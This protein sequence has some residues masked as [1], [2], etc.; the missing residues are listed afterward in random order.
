MAPSV[1]V[2]YDGTSNDDD[3]LA[4]ARQLAAAGAGLAL[5]YVRHSREYDPRREEIAE[6]DAA[7]RLEQGAAWLEDPDITRHVVVDPSTST[8]LARLAAET[9]AQ[10]VLF[11]SDYRTTPGRAEPGGTAQGLL[12]GGSVA[13]GVAQAG[14]RTHAGAP[15]RSVAAAGD[16]GGPA[17]QTVRSLAAALDAEVVSVGGGADLIVADSQSNAP[18]GRI[19]LGGSTRARLDAALGSVVVLPRGT[20]LSF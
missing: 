20:A 9:G 1:I 12:E 14:L 6:Y 13:I 10:L 5:A 18:E 3:A 2:S 19:A 15:I 8:G 11:G 7:R 4:L 17:E 16:A